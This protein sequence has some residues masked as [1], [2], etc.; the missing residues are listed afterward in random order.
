MTEKGSLPARAL[1]A[2]L[3]SH[4]SMVGSVH[5]Y[6]SWHDTYAGPEVPL[7]L[8]IWKHRSHH[9]RPKTVSQVSQQNYK[10][11]SSKHYNINTILHEITGA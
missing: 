5:S 7:I 6:G 3:N 1:T 9:K 11:K 2:A 10:Y 4:S 8:Y